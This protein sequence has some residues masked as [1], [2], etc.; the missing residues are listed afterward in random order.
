MAIYKEE[1]YM[2]FASQIRSGVLRPLIATVQLKTYWSL[3][4]H[5]AEVFR[6]RDETLM[7]LRYLLMMQTI[8]PH[9]RHLH[10][11]FQPS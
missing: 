1:R 4:A 10:Q 8:G 11:E 2:A 5:L 6:L 7:T 9:F 3:L